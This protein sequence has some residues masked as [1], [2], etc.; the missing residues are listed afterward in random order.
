L[1]LV[2]LAAGSGKFRFSGFSA[3]PFVG[4][5]KPEKLADF[6]ALIWIE[7]SRPFRIL[8]LEE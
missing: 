6:A 4:T 1:V 7:V 3:L 5:L 2:S 8:D